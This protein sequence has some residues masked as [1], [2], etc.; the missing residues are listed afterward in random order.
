MNAADTV[1]ALVELS[2]TMSDGEQFLRDVRDG[3]IKHVGDGAALQ[4]IITTPDGN[5]GELKAEVEQML[6][7]KHNR[8]IVITE[9]A[10][11]SILGGA[12]VTVGDEQIDL[13]VRG[14]LRQA[15]ERMSGITPSSRS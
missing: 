13:S 9:K 11:K 1:Q 2:R 12:I 10:D 3:L 14:S 4:V 15:A 7:K 5:A 6:Q 8:P